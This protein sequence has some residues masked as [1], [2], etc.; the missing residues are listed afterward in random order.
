MTMK[1]RALV[2]LMLA[3]VAIC[4]TG[5]G[6][7]NCGATF[8][9][10]SCSTT[11]GGISQGPGTNSSGV[12][13]AFLLA[14]GHSNPPG[15]A[16]DQLDLSTNTFS[17][18]GSATFPP[19]P[20]TLTSGAIDG[21]TV[22]VSATKV[23]Y[24]Y[25]PF[26]DSTLWGFAI[27]GAT[28]VLSPVPNSP[29]VATGGTSIA[30]DPAGRFLFVSDFASG[31]ITAFTINPNDG[32]LTVVGAATPSGIAAAQ[33]STDGQGKFLFATEGLGGLHVAAFAINQ[34]TG[35]LSAAGSPVLFSPGMAQVEGE[36]SGKFLMGISGVDTKIHVFSINATSGALAEVSGSPF[37]TVTAPGSIV[38]H[39]TGS[40]VY[41]FTS[42]ADGVEGFQIDPTSGALTAIAGSPFAGAML[43]EGQFDQSGKFLFGVGS[44]AIGAPTFG[45]YPTDPTTGIISATTFTLE[46]F[47]GSGFAVSDLDNAP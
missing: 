42:A 31:D 13:M 7:Y 8:G 38:V 14:E 6:H 43:G 3:T 44:G 2:G 10:S 37:T 17:I 15:M 39:P 23:K 47:P 21:G 34:T 40:F 32:S 11:P 12:V 29:F 24:L 27:D 16:A 20:L 18:L 1:V 26:S 4:L 35:A 28:G 19:P 41:S 33:M 45:P 36:K 30:A 9:N 22:V 5:C 46:G 25:I